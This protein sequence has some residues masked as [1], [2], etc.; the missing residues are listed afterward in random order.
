MYDL[1]IIGSKY[2]DHLR[3]EQEG[4]A[5][6]VYKVYAVFYKG[7]KEFEIELFSSEDA[8]EAIQWAI[9][10]H[11]D[12]RISSPVELKDGIVGRK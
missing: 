1:Q 4:K 11:M 2:A 3:V 9:D 12:I 10:H 7:N 6:K 5:V 8:S